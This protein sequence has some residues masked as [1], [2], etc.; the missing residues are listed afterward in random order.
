MTDLRYAVRALW[1]TPT[2]TLLVL[3]ILALG[4]G[5][6]T[7]IFTVANGVLFRPLPFAEPDRLVQFG[8]T[9]VL[10]FKAYRDQ[11]RSFASLISYTVVNKN[12]RGDGEPERVTAVTAEAGLF[13]LLGV[14]ALSGRTFSARD[15]RDVVVVGESFWQ[16][17]SGGR[18][19]QDWKI[20]LDGEPY[21][22]IGI[23]PRSLSFPSSGTPADVWIPAELPRTD[24]WFQRIDAA[25][26]RMNPGITVD[27]ARAELT[28]IAQ[29]L[30]P[31]SA[32]NPGR[33]VTIVPLTDAVVGRSRTSV[34][35]LVGAVGM[36]LLVACANVANLLL[37]RAEARRRDVAIRTALGA[38]RGRLARQFLT[39]SVLLVST[40]SAGAMLV[41]VLGVRML[42]TLG[43]S[44]IPR[45]AEIGV[46]WTTF[47]FVLAIGS[48]TAIVFG[49]VPALHSLRSDVVDAL[50]AISSRTSPG[51]RSSVVTRALVVV[52]VA[53]ALVLL[54]GAGLLMR[55]FIALDQAP[56]GIAANH[57]LTLRIESRG[58][59]PTA[60]TAIEPGQPTPQGRYF[61]DIEQRVLRIPGV[62]AAGFVARLHVQ[63]PGNLGQFTIADGA[64]SSERGTAARLRD[65]TPGYFRTLG[66]PL[67]SGRLFTEQGTGI[68]VNETLAR[69]AFPGQN[70][71]GRVL[72]RGT[73][74]GVVADV[75]QRLRVPA[76]PEI[77]TPLSRMTYSAATLV[78]QSD[79][80]VEPLVASLRTAIA[81]INPNQPVFDVR[82]MEAVVAAAHDDVDLS[83]A[84][85]GSFAALAFVLAVAGIYGVLSFAVEVRRTEFGIR[86]ALGA[87]AGRVLRLVLT[88]GGVLILIGVISGIAGAVMLTRFLRA[89]LYEVTPTDPVTFTGATLL[90]VTV[91]VLACLEP[92]RRAMRVDPMIVL[93]QG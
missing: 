41:A 58:L 19:I 25:V 2:L 38:G 36:V 47:L 61:R 14:R 52:E 86:L 24:N 12:V 67:R 29:R 68:L 40:A 1:R 22:V 15:P 42:V 39:E 20:V 6:T 79:V 92:A 75:R 69:S 16:R 21:T 80:A 27:A 59:L 5:S 45:A 62:R 90:L 23:L 77:Y 34:L 3:L 43:A 74:V 78:V 87:D 8:T 4:I 53:L 26:G 10:E 93:R 35:T 49:L 46:D 63:S 18:P 28:S 85:I 57:V 50:N 30:E 84:V 60:D 51:R 72:N 13:D 64:S 9:G 11:S 76:E 89:L 91:A 66:I 7:A 82:T 32:S 88:Q 54:T 83:L 44:Q 33:T 70:P 71:I 37:A 65:V 81:E 48:L 73:I 31:L 56:L 55:A 17:R